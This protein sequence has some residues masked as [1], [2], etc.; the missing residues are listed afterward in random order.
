[1]KILITGI[2]GYLGTYLA[3]ELGLKGGLDITGI[4]NNNKKEFDYINL[5][6]CNL[7]ELDELTKIFNEV[8]PDVV[9]HLA[10]V[11]P[12]RIEKLSD[13]Y[14]EF[15]NNK[16]TEHIAKLC[17]ENDSLLI[18]TSTDLVYAEGENLKEDT[19]KLKPVT[20]YAKSKLMGENSV[21]AYAK[22]YLILR[23][24]LLYGF[25]RSAYTSFFDFAYNKLKSGESINSFID[26]FRNPLYV[27]ES[28]KILA[29]LPGVYKQNDT[30][31]LCGDEY[32]SRHDMCLMMAEFFGFDKNLVKMASSGE[33]TDYPLVKKIGL[34]SDKLKS[35]GFTTDSF[36][37]NLHKSLKY[38]Y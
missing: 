11:T 24:S 3:Y 29:E 26:Q 12:T 27:E 25:T 33:F 9:Y 10:S 13:Q 19:A 6:Q 7:T 8:K 15:F 30:I 18:Y 5:I 21:W 14:V 4:Y 35:F 2:S 16:V 23:S 17:G 1:M 34:N 31:N 22:K 20:I 28:A 32:L 38:T 36:E 37:K